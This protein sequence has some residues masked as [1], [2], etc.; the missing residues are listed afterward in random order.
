MPPKM[1]IIE[2]SPAALNAVLD[3]KFTYADKDGAH[4]AVII[5]IPSGGRYVITFGISSKDS[6]Q[7]FGGLVL[8]R[9]IIGGT[10]KIEF[11]N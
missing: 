2:V 9:E 6:G 11:A 3:V 5:F 10:C 8:D 7:N 1:Q 4:N